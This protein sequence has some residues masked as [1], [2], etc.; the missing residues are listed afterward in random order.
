MEIV[1]S[2]C[3]DCGATL[4][5]PLSFDNVTC[6]QC[7]SAFNVSHYKNVVSLQRIGRTAVDED[8]ELAA[9]LRTAISELDEQIVEIKDRIE[10]LRSSEQ[11]AALQAGCAVFGVFGT[12]IVV[13]ALFVTVG[14]AYFGHWIFYAALA[15]VLIAAGARIRNRLLTKEQRRKL[16]EER[17]LLEE[18]L[19]R[20]EADRERLLDL[21]DPQ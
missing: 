5:F 12:I 15:L 10:A 7:S 6:R 2:Q 9:E 14:R 3:P 8:A 17:R 11:G 13:L 1:S 18:A 20:L 19:A 21:G 16:I 4:E